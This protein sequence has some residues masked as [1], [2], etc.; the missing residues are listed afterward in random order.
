MSTKCVTW[1]QFQNRRRIGP[2]E[3]STKA[4]VIMAKT[5]PDTIICNLSGLEHFLWWA[6]WQRPPPHER[7]RPHRQGTVGP[8]EDVRQDCHQFVPKQTPIEGDTKEESEEGV[9]CGQSQGGRDGALRNLTCEFGGVFEDPFGS[10]C[11]VVIIII[12]KKSPTNCRAFISKHM[13]K[14]TTHEASAAC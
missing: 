4:E 14:C 5:R 2:S 8:T 10:L 9:V 3:V 1:K 6:L 7:P 11:F 12:S 13:R